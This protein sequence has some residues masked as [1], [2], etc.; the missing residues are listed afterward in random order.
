MDRFGKLKNYVENDKWV[1]D[2]IKEL[3]LETIEK[4][5][6][7]AMNMANETVNKITLAWFREHQAEGNRGREIEQLRKEKESLMK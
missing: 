7:F 4:I 3:Q 1:P 5:Y 2:H 6:A